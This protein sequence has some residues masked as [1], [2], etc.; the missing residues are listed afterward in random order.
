MKR[1]IMMIRRKEN[2]KELREDGTRLWTTHNQNSWQCSVGAENTVTPLLIWRGN[3][4]AHRWLLCS[5]G[6]QCNALGLWGMNE[7]GKK[8]K[9]KSGAGLHS[10]AVTQ[11][12]EEQ[13]N[14]SDRPRHVQVNRWEV[15]TRTERRIQVTFASERNRKKVI[16]TL[17]SSGCFGEVVNF[18]FFHGQF[19][20]W[21]GNHSIRLLL[22]KVRSLSLELDSSHVFL[23]IRYSQ[24][25]H[26]KHRRIT[27]AAE[28]YVR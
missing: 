17:C 10:L 23:F 1:R 16:S 13:G 12:K 15:R 18:F 25:V 24:W 11:M 14:N 27:L 2:E 26:Q 3:Y 20:E 7:R 21:S 8:K 19:V 6:G 9:Q 4:R 5:R 28:N 22:L